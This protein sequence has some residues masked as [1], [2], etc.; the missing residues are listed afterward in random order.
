MNKNRLL[1]FISIG[2]S[3]VLLGLWPY[4][5]HRSAQDSTQNSP[6][7]TLKQKEQEFLS[8]LQ[9]EPP[10]KLVE[11]LRQSNNSHK[12]KRELP[13]LSLSANDISLLT[14]KSWDEK[15]FQK[16]AQN[17]IAQNKVSEKENSKDYQHEDYQ[18]LIQ[19]SEWDLYQLPQNNQEF[20]LWLNEATLHSYYKLSVAIE[21]QKSS[22]A[23]LAAAAIEALKFMTIFE[24]K[25]YNKENRWVLSLKKERDFVS[26]YF[27][28]SPSRLPATEVKNSLFSMT[29]DDPN[30]FSEEEQKAL[31]SLKKDQTP[32]GK[33]LSGHDERYSLYTKGDELSVKTFEF[34]E[35]IV[36]LT[37][38]VGFASDPKS[39][40]LSNQKVIDDIIESIQEKPAAYGFTKKNFE[41]IKDFNITDMD[42]HFLIQRTVSE[43]AKFTALWGAGLSSTLGSYLGTLINSTRAWSLAIAASMGIETIFMTYACYQGLKKLYVLHRYY[44]YMNGRRKASEFKYE[45]FNVLA[46]KQ[47]FEPDSVHFDRHFQK[48]AFRSW[49]IALSLGFSVNKF[50]SRKYVENFIR[51]GLAKTLKYT[52]GS[53]RIPT[54]ILSVATFKT[55]KSITK[56]LQSKT[57]RLF[58][59]KFFPRLPILP[60]KGSRFWNVTRQFAFLSPANLALTGIDFGITGISMFSLTYMILYHSGL[61]LTQTDPSPSMSIQ[62]SLAS[63]QER[64]L[65]F[66]VATQEI[67]YPLCIHL[68]LKKTEGVYEKDLSL[69]KSRQEA[70]LNIISALEG[71]PRRAIANLLPHIYTPLTSNKITHLDYQQYLNLIEKAHQFPSEYRIVWLSALR[72]IYNLEHVPELYWVV[73]A[74]LLAN[75]SA[76]IHGLFHDLSSLF[77]SPVVSRNYM[78]SERLN[79]A[80]ELLAVDMERF[81]FPEDQRPQRD[82][83]TL[84]DNL[85]SLDQAWIA[86]MKYY[87]DITKKNVASLV[88]MS[89]DKEDVGHLQAVG[90]TFASY[91]HIIK[92][93][94]K[95]FWADPSHWAFRN[96]VKE[97]NGLIL[98]KNKENSSAF[99][100]EQL[101]DNR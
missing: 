28:A 50:L 76:D 26:K 4:L 96:K 74:K 62:L 32:Y 78:N 83:S 44:S 18:H 10:Q 22:K 49:L 85:P 101:N 14:H 92:T 88:K 20:T 2:V 53:R 41:K 68:A 35:Y 82:D 46:A 11:E 36:K 61:A 16:W 81:K 7:K 95:V 84:A 90:D 5:S 64:N 3:I 99:S 67:F 19:Q 57:W 69:R 65:D 97:T 21:K 79:Y 72:S 94:W 60:V 56:I 43:Q 23:I 24:F 31:L 87:Q 54:N 73:Q 52:K 30:V 34:L 39:Y 29:S 80:I 9:Q 6:A 42:M 75:P 51:N 13:K 91:G 55:S 15:K 58:A 59:L 38:G 77:R 93:G 33:P 71:Q 47:D 100:Y 27:K 63:F 98:Q 66:Y 1:I 89:V 12:F 17:K 48:D 40:H 70:C 8:Q 86:Y 37:S 25:G 45:T